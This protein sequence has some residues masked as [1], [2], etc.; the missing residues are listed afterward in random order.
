MIRLRFLVG[1]LLVVYAR[2]KQHGLSEL[3]VML[4]LWVY[5]NE[6]RPTNPFRLAKHFFRSREGVAKMMSKMGDLVQAQRVNRNLYRYY[7]TDK[8]VRVLNYL[9]SGDSKKC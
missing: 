6:G 8:G 2:F 4:L 3:S 5:L 7:L 1:N 9:L